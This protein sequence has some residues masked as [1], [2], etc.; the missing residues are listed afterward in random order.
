MFTPVCSVIIHNYYFVIKIFTPFISLVK[1]LDCI[2]CSRICNRGKQR[3]IL[4][5]DSSN[6][7]NVLLFLLSPLNY[8]RQHWIFWLPYFC[9]CSPTVSRCFIHVNDFPSLHHE[10]ENLFDVVDSQPYRFLFTSSTVETAMD[11]KIANVKL[12]IAIGQSKSRHRN[13]ISRF[14]NTA[15]CFKWKMCPLSKYTW[16]FQ[17]LSNMFDPISYHYCSFDNFPPFLFLRLSRN[18]SVTF[19]IFLNDLI[20]CGSCNTHP[21]CNIWNW[22]YCRLQI[23]ILA[24]SQFDDLDFHCKLYLWSMF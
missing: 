2:Y 20:Y 11:L 1:V 17:N 23:P 4:Y 19:D 18:H 10:F 12:F 3:I 16:I 24:E 6:D 5:T 15:S 8:K 9:P 21:F 14:Q 13:P 22:H 7:C